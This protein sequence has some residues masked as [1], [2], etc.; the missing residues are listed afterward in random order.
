M[1]DLRLPMHLHTEAMPDDP[2]VVAFLQGPIVLAADLGAGS[3]GADRFGP[4]APELRADA[5]P[6]TPTLV[7]PTT[8][9]ALARLRPTGE[10][11][12]FRTEGLGRPVDVV[13]R[14]FFRLYDRRHAVYLPVLT[15][16]AWAD[17]GAREASASAAR[18]AVLAR[19]VDLVVAGS[20]PEEAAHAALAERAQVSS[21]EGRPC[22]STRY[23]GS[24][25]YALRVPPE[26]PAAV[27]VT[28]WGG[29]TRRHVF[30][31][32]VED[33]TIATQSLFDDLPGELYEVEYPL[34][35]RLVRGRDR[36]RVGFRTGAG[37]STGSVFEV[38]VVRDPNP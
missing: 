2:A 34:P 8:A 20:L 26:G 16:A 27:R 9:A 33:E 3:A 5:S 12:T 23:G 22:R 17:R 13:L 14:P 36:V 29:E 37:Q 18:R 28:Y 4:Q 38:R 31:V 35:Q 15:E 21:L 11:L 30:D 10:P 1:V 6:I 32:T 24:F 7:A 19:T 25:S